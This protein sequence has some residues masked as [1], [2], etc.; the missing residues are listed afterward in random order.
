MA[1]L[2][3]KRMKKLQV[4]QEFP[5]S[6]T[7]H[8]II[9]MRR[10]LVCVFDKDISKLEKDKGQLEKRL[11]E[12][13]NGKLLSDK[14]KRSKPDEDEDEDEDDCAAELSEEEAK[15]LEEEVRKDL[16]E[17]VEKSS[18]FIAMQG[19]GSRV[20]PSGEVLSSQSNVERDAE[21]GALEYKGRT[22]ERNKCYSYQDPELKK[23]WIVGIKGFYPKTRSV[24]CVLIFH[25]S[26]TFL[27]AEDPDIAYKV[28][29]TPS[30]YFQIKKPLKPLSLECF[31]SDFIH[32]KE[33]PEWVA[34]PQTEGSWYNFAYFREGRRELCGP[35]GDIR[36]MECFAGAGG[37]SLGFANRGFRTVLAI[38]NNSAAAEAYRVNFKDAPILCG[39]VVEVLRDDKQMEAVGIVTHLHGSSPCQ[40]FSEANIVNTP[41]K[42][43]KAKAQNELSLQW[44]VGIE[45]KRPVSASFENVKGMWNRKHQPYLRRILERLLKAGYQIRVCLMKTCDYGDP[46]AR[47]RF[48]IFAAAEY[49]VLPDVP[50]PTHGPGCAHDYITAKDAIGDLSDPSTAHQDMP[51]DVDRLDPDSPSKTLLAS[52]TPYHYEQNRKITVREKSRLC[53]FPDTFV[54]AGSQEQQLKQIGNCVPTRTSRAIAGAFEASLVYRYHGESR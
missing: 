43:A 34:E 39:D 3:K 49:A 17:K 50:K 46:Q 30:E 6:S 42:E 25:H 13:R 32:Q 44:V 52:K 1:D 26:E 38:E 7:R 53:S 5:S 36:L 4:L 28:T 21:L 14:L 10:H 51:D 40:G 45:K 15:R 47:E 54:F 23:P 31:G 22:F 33:I 18:L 11:K 16:V 20:Q 24:N 35:R 37:M 9:E 8:E 27:W 12:N 29:Y 2:E 41:E 19:L 48:F